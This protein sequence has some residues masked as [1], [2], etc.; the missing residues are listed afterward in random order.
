MEVPLFVLAVVV[1]IAFLVWLYFKQN[2]PVGKWVGGVASIALLGMMLATL[3]YAVWED[4]D[5]KGYIP[6]SR[7]TSITAESSWLDGESKTCVA[8]PIGATRDVTSFVNC[9]RGPAHQI[10][11][12]FW[13]RAERPEVTTDRSVGWKCIKEDGRFV[14]YAV[15]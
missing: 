10:T 13:G 4:M 6:H 14:C 9:D 2:T 15:D 1:L 8:F 7:E 12:K 11:V 5:K 3:S